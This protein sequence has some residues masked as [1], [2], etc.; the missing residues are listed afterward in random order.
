MTYSYG[1][2]DL[3]ISDLQSIVNTLTITNINLV[4]NFNHNLLNIIFLTNKNIKLFLKKVG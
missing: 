2:M 3:E 4:L 1:N